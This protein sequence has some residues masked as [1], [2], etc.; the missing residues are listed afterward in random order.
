MLNLYWD[1][2]SANDELKV[3]QSALETTQKFLHDTQTEI[4]A[5]AMPRVELPRAEAEAAGREH[6]VVVAQYEVRQ[7]EGMLKDAITRTHRFPR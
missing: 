6:D 4:A 3:R 1:L 7:R 5:G 2:V